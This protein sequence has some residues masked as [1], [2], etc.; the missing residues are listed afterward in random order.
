MMRKL[1]LLVFLIVAVPLAG[2]SFDDEQ[3]TL[4][5]TTTEQTCTFTKPAKLLT[6]INDGSSEIHI[7]FN[8]TAISGTTNTIAIKSAES[9]SWDF[10]VGNVAFG[11]KAFGYICT[12]TTATIRVFAI[13]D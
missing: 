3:Q 7:N 4:S 9:W 13:T 11:I 12:P 1:L 2:F 5:A 8:G 10:S 6:I